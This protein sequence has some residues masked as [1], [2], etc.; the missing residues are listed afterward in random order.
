MSYSTTLLRSIVRCGLI[1]QTSLPVK[2][3][4]E[5]VGDTV[6]MALVGVTLVTGERDRFAQ[7][8]PNA[9]FCQSIA[10]SRKAFPLVCPKKGVEIRLGF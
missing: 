5:C 10:L 9:D 4:A 6:P 8:Q 3:L 7:L 1:K 2:D